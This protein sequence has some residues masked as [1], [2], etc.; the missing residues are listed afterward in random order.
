M[1]APGEA[2]CLMSPQADDAVEAFLER[3]P[4]RPYRLTRSDGADFPPVELEPVTV[5]D[6]LW[7]LDEVPAQPPLGS[8][9]RSDDS[10]GENCHLWV[11]DARGRP[12]IS[13]AP[14]E[15][16]ASGKRLKHTN[17]TGGGEASIGGEVW[18][19]EKPLIY[20]SGS[21]GRYPPRNEEHL[22]DAEALFRAVGFDV[23][24]LGWDSETG[25]P[26]RVWQEPRSAV[27]G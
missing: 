7:Y 20:L 16:L 1:M 2:H 14:L 6:G 25:K 22:K 12:C 4:L 24:A 18:F 15:R 11:I 10:H 19:G 3:Y 17:L 8:P 5:E 21:S 23:M 9:R 13:E 27:N 26:R